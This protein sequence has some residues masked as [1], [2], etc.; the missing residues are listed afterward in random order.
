MSSSVTLALFALAALTVSWLIPRG[1]SAPFQT[2]ERPKFK[3]LSLH[4]MQLVSATP[5]GDVH[6]KSG[7]SNDPSTDFYQNS[8][9]YPKVS[10]ESVAYPDKY[11]IIDDKTG[12]IRV[13]TPED[14]NEI[15]RQIMHPTVYSSF[16]L[17]SYKNTNC[18]LAFDRYG[19]V[20]TDPGI[21]DDNELHTG[22][23]LHTSVHVYT[24]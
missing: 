6:A 2:P 15:L 16:A 1:S 9:A 22:H 21:C 13:E 11:I 24:T 3:I 4:S 23:G 19:E 7:N 10:Y 12:E 20:S 14:D 18:Y 8:Y 17:Q 5:H